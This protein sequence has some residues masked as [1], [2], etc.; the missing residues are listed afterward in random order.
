MKELVEHLRIDN[1]RQN[2]SVNDSSDRVKLGLH[3]GGEGSFV[4]KGKSGGWKDYLDQEKIH[5][6]EK[7]KETNAK[8]LD[9]PLDKLWS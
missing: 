4:R 8:E 5:R 2:K 3:I 6:M 9:L 7:W 1:L